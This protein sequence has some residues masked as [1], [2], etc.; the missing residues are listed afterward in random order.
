M[1]DNQPFNLHRAKVQPEWIDYNGHMNVAYYVLAFDQATDTFIEHVGIDES[2]RQATDCSIF[3]SETHVNY[4]RELREGTPLAVTTQILDLNEKRIHLFHQMFHA[5]EGYLAAS[6][7]III[8]HVDLKRRRSVD[9]RGDP[10]EKL[11]QLHVI[12]REIPWP[13][14]AGRH[15][16]IKRG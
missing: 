13:E 9:W 1:T 8:V 3:V 12:H 6:T 16:G 15:I 2:Y 4:L 7:D 5:E 14:K 10:A 11:K